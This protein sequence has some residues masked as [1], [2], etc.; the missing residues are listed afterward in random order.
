[1]PKFRLKVFKILNKASQNGQ[2]FFSQSGEISPNLVTL[3]GINVGRAFVNK[4]NNEVRF[5]RCD[6]KTFFK[7]GTMAK[8]S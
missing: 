4:K 6:D 8:Q 5:V 7:K 2:I 1:M 3:L